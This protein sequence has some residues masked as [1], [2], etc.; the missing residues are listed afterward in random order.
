MFISSGIQ[1]NDSSHSLHYDDVN[2]A[3]DKQHAK[4]DTW[5]SDPT[6]LFPD[7][8]LSPLIIEQLQATLQEMPKGK[9]V[10]IPANNDYDSLGE[11]DALFKDTVCFLLCIPQALLMVVAAA[12]APTDCCQPLPTPCRACSL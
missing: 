11:Y 12:L 8:A 4:L 5:P 7:D 3:V 6:R 2:K 10:V 1:E 9:P